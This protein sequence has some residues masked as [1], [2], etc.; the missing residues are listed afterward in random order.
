MTNQI[1]AAAARLYALHAEQ[2]PLNQILTAAVVEMQDR[3]IPLYRGA[4]VRPP[5]HL[6]DLDFIDNERSTDSIVH[7]FYTDGHG[8]KVAGTVSVEE[9][10]D[11]E[12]AAARTLDRI[13]VLVELTALEAAEAEIQR[14]RDHL[15]TLKTNR[16]R[17]DRRR[18][19]VASDGDGARIEETALRARRAA[20][21]A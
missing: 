10:T 12:L 1:G 21:A 17:D 4:N 8:E 5:A 13:A 20:V 7:W 15:R 19:D 14:R 11:P 18:G 3:L 6:L 9:L 2:L 16:A